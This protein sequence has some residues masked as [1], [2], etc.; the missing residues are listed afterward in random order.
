MFQNKYTLMHGFFNNS[1][2][3]NFPHNLI[4]IRFTLKWNGI[5][6]MKFC[7]N[8]TCLHFSICR[9]LCYT[10]CLLVASVLN[11]FIFVYHE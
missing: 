4:K 5:T 1:K 9:C 2:V 6:E 3:A 8:L 11:K 10:E 7:K